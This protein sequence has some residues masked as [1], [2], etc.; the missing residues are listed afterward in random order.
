MKHK[1]FTN[2]LINESSPYLLMHA[3]NPVDWYPWGSEALEKA[4]EEN[5]LLIISIGYAACHWCH[6][7]EKE[8]FADEETAQI[9]NKYFIAI[10][11]D[12]EER[13]DI[14][15]VYMTASHLL[16]G[17]GGW[18]LNAV[19]LPDGRPFFAGTYFPKKQWILLL[20][21]IQRIY[22]D[23][24]QQ[25]EAQAES[26]SQGVR[27][28][29]EISINLTDISLDPA[30]LDQIFENWQGSIDYQWGGEKRAPKFPLPVGY[31]YLLTYF[32]LTQ[33]ARALE[34]VTITLDKMAMGGIY[35]QIGGGF[36][37]Y[38]TDTFWKVPHFEK[39]L[40]DNAQLVSLYS[41]AY[42]ATENPLYKAVVYETLDFVERELTSPEI[43]GGAGGGRGFY[44]S[45]DADSEGEEGKFYLW[46][47]SEIQRVLAG[48]APLVI[49]YYN[50]T[51]QGNWEN[52][53]N[54]LHRLE[55]DEAFTETR[56]ISRQQLEEHIRSAKQKL[57]AVR[58]H[59]VR[60]ALDDK[61]L[62]AWNALMLTGYVDAYRAFGDERF[63]KQ[64][65]KNAGFITG[66]MMSPDGRLYRNYKNGKCTINAFLDDYAFTIAAFIS[67]Y[68]AT[69]AG[70]W[71]SL[72]RD[73]TRYT[74]DHFYDKTGGMF[75]YTSDQDP[76]LIARK[77]EISDNVIPSSNSRMALNLYLLG[78]YFSAED[79][80]LKARQMLNNIKPALVSG[81]SYYAN[82]DLLMAYFVFP[83]FEVAVV[84][85]DWEQKRKELERR[86][87]PQM[88]LMGG[89]EEGHLPFLKGKL[90]KGKTLIY[91][92]RDKRCML[93]VV[94]V[95]EAL[96]QME[97]K[98]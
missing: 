59:R 51:D 67:L 55:T 50:V 1:L 56:K 58:S 52:G 78:E 71:L 49:D 35:D 72:A 7:M 33:K 31:Q 44:S 8:S 77:M 79:Y 23:N 34:A 2:H 20:E 91:I 96:K 18:P 16:T 17:G 81:G 54:I 88:I 48:D 21:Q 26:L 5:K 12:R 62:T 25:I 41:H 4:K 9:M 47:K 30:V 92:C 45:L 53:Q 90:Q 61:I 89:A 60:P 95:E 24:P 68:R 13:P 63:L 6:V 10:K 46:T 85:D 75:Y 64:A 94:E 14:D 28:T 32:H 39:M 29:G 40:Y 27:S 38:S 42:Q 93:P 65:L 3:H 74:L 80:T 66:N 82:W 70:Q 73:L 87:L 76:G 86:F 36:A 83:P 98:P 43:P 11:V 97:R 37:R 69:F 57:L 84:G 19:A 15:Q 22:R